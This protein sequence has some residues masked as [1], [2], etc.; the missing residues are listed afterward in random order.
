MSL[1]VVHTRAQLGV[2][3]PAVRVEVHLAGG[4]PSFNIVGLPETAVRESRDRV[5]AAMANSGFQPPARRV[6]VS[7]APADLPKD[8]GRFDLPIALGVLVA[9]GQVRTDALDDFEFLGELALGGELRPVVGTL[10]ALI[11]AREAGRTLVLPADNG[12]EAGLV[13]NADCRLAD[14]LPDVAAVRG[15]ARARRALEVAAA[16]GHNLLLIGPPG[17]GKTLLASRLP[18]ILPPLSE[19][20]A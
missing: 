15:Q 10:P 4:L 16:G 7:L 3:A 18:G 14:R 6:T 9:S 5:R 1:A 12:T 20:E 11:R 8:G 17:T 2:T 13:R 19:E